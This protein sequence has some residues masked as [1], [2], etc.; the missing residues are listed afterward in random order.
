MW[1]YFLPPN[2]LDILFGVAFRFKLTD[3]GSPKKAINQ[4]GS[5][6]PSWAHPLHNSFASMTLEK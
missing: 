4:T 5:A 3:D 2:V 1:T 6:G